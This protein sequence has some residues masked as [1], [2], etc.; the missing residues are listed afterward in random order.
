[1]T[2][3]IL[4]TVARALTPVVVIL[5]IY[6][7]LRGHDAPG[8]GFIGGL[9]GGAA[10]VLQYLGHGPERTTRLLP[11]RFDILL[12]IGLLAAVGTGLVALLLGGHFLEGGLWKH[13]LPLIGEL[14]VAASLAFDVGVFLVVLSVVTAIVT[15]LGERSE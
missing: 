8:G 9:V 15:S 2:T 10:V 3:V 6:L 5:S 1:M 11:V 12:G 7:L 14:K 4:R 13:E